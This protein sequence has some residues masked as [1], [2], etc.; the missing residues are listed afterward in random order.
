MLLDISYNLNTEQ[1]SF[2]FGSIPVYSNETPGCFAMN[3][4][5]SKT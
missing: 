1:T 2:F 3:S 4:L 5:L